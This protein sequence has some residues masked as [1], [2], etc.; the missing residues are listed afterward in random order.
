MPQTRPS[1]M[2]PLS[3]V[4]RAIVRA[5]ID[6]SVDDYELVIDPHRSPRDQRD[7]LDGGRAG[8]SARSGGAVA[9][10]AHLV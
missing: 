6:A 10:R 4:T 5:V 8:E 1:S 9:A 7:P 2:V 3:L